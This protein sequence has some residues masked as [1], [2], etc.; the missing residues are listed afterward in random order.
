MTCSRSKV[1]ND[2]REIP[3]N[4][5]NKTDK[6][7]HIYMTPKISLSAVWVFHVTVERILKKGNKSAL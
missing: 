4:G 6:I 5:E 3:S 1:G 7:Y 2:N